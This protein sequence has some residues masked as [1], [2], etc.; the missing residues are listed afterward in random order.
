MKKAFSIVGMF[1]GI[2]FIVV[3][4]LA[5]SGTFGGNTSSPSSAPSAYDSGYASFGADY[6]TYSVNNSAEAASAARTAANNIGDIAEFMVTFGGIV[7]ILVGLAVLCG[8][9]YAFA[10]V[11]AGVVNMPVAAV[12]APVD[13]GD[14]VSSETTEE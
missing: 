3:G 12:A 13:N 7:S 4:I 8:F 6:Y 5:T 14:S 10:S 2:A 1:V 11:N 9:G